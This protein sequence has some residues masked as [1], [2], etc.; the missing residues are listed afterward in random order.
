MN[1]TVTHSAQKELSFEIRYLIARF[2]R[3]Q[4]L[5]AIL[6]TFWKGKGRPPDATPRLNNHLRKDIGLPELVEPSHRKGS[7]KA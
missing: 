6:T 7:T 1:Q 2:G 5:F 3:R 4:A